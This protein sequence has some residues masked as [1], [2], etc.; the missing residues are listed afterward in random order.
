MP[1]KV[2]CDGTM[3]TD[4][5]RGHDHGR[6]FLALRLTAGQFI[7]NW[8]TPKTAGECYRVT[9]TTQDDSPLVAFFKLK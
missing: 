5:H 2:A 6:H 3:P 9:V 1:T 8:Q 7:Q 4:E